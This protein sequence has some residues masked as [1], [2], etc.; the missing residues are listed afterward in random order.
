[1]SDYTVYY[2]ANSFGGGLEFKYDVTFT[3]DP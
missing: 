3:M 2:E 1:M